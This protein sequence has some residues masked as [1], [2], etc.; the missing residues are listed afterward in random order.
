VPEALLMDQGAGVHMQVELARAL[1]VWP[2][3]GRPLVAGHEP[4]PDGRCQGC[5]AQMALAPKSLAPKSPCNLL[6][7][8]VIHSRVGYRRCAEVA[9]NCC[10]GAGR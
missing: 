5:R 9:A 1:A 7:N 4:G 2:T 6:A 3:I 8:V 10:S